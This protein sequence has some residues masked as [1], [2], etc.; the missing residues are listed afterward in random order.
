MQAVDTL[1]QQAR[2]RAKAC[3]GATAWPTA[4]L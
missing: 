2:A 3:M 1:D 4:L